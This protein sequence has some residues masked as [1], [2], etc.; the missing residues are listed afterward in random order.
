MINQGDLRFLQRCVALAEEA[1][2]GGDMPFGSVLVSAEG[3]DIG[4]GS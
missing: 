1:L 3:G 2:A 4:R